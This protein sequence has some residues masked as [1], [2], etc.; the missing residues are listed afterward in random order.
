M[1]KMV[2]SQCQLELQ[3]QKTGVILIEMADFG[4]YKIWSAD[5]WRCP[6]CGM[7][8]VAGFADEPIRIHHEDDFPAV[9]AG[10]HAN[11]DAWILYD[12]ESQEQRNKSRKANVL[13][14]PEWDDIPF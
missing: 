4:E 1:P 9:L 5:L 2:C 11:P 7:G 13:H 12:Y 8:I 6:D 10:I 3:P 14:L